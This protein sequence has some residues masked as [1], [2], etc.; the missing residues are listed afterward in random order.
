VDVGS[1]PWIASDKG[2]EYI[3]NPNAAKAPR[4]IVIAIDGPAAAGKSTTARLVAQRVGY[5]HIDTGA[6]YRAFTWK[7]LREKVSLS[8]KDA[9]AEVAGKTEVRLVPDSKFDRVFVDGQ[10]VTDFIRSPEVTKNVSFVS[11]IQAVR[12]VMVREQRKMATN[13]SVVLE[14]RDIGT[15]VLPEAELKIFMVADVVERARRRRK[16]LS[17]AGVEASEDQLVKEIEERDEK[18]SNRSS[19]PLRKAKDA[20]VLDTSHLTIDQQVEAIVKRAVEILEKRGIA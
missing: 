14:G 5:L 20:V 15:V 7:L 13:G 6:M 16:E 10:E 12:D 9:I 2:I 3:M 1:S 18:D 17:S 4:G 11:S 8:S 19:S